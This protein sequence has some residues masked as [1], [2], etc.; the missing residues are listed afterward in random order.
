MA[1]KKKIH[2]GT[3]GWSYP[4]W[5]GIFY[6]ENVKSKERLEYFSRFFETVEINNSFY[7]L[8]G[9]KTFSS[10]KKKTGDNFLFSVKANRFITHIKRLKNV[11]T[12]WK[13]LFSRA[14]KLEEKLG[15]IL[16]QFP[17]SFRCDDKNFKRLK[18]FLNYLSRDLKVAFEFRHQSWHCRKV[19]NLLIR[20]K[21]AQVIAY[22]SEYPNKE[23][24][25]APYMYIRMHGPGKLFSSDY[26][27]NELKKLSTKIKKWPADE[28]FVYFNNDYKGHAL[29]NARFL[30]EEL[31]S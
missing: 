18:N 2:I 30:K 11:K 27:S 16:L 17:S 4:H 29:K 31:N 23:L 5:Q 3:S 26:N 28:V 1:E 20:N 7:Q 19:E 6:P 14:E 10:W 13:K 21:K 25:T 9:A 8:P 15:P 12:A 24:I 22:S